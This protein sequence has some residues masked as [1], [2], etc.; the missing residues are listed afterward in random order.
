MQKEVKDELA[1]MVRQATE[2]HEGLTRETKSSLTNQALQLEKSMQDSGLRLTRELRDLESVL[3]ERLERT[4]DALDTKIDVSNPYQYPEPSPVLP[5][6]G[7]TS[8]MVL[9][10]RRRGH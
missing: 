1:A 5:S 8:S 6:D 10:R 7:L 4:K 2:R 9:C 3:G